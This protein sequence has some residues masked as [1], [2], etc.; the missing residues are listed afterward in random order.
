[1]T[2]D[3]YFSSALPSPND[4]MH[5]KKSHGGSLVQRWTLLTYDI[6]YLEAEGSEKTY[7][8]KQEDIAA[9]VPVGSSQQVLA[10]L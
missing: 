5:G 1:M 9:V 6:R 8:I 3:C 4:V 2:N 7:K 10:K